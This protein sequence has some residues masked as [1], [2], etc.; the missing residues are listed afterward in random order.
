DPGA[1]LAVRLTDAGARLLVVDAHSV[2]TFD[3]DSVRRLRS[4]AITPAPAAPSAA[5]ISPDGST[6]AVGS[7]TGQVSF[8]DSSTGHARPGTG[9]HGSAVTSLTY[10]PDGRAVASTGADNNVTIWDPRA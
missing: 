3:A 2:S 9:A 7:P 4:A 10:S 5:A 1:V 6:V 8:V